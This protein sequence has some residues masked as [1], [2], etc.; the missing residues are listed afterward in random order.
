MG[1]RFNSRIGILPRRRINLSKCGVSL[2]AEGAARSSR[3]VARRTSRSASP[4]A[5]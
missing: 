3:S 1:F 5:A 4:V 2:S